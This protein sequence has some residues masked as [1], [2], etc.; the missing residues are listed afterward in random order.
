MTTEEKYY[1]K[2]FNITK[3]TLSVDEKRCI[4]IMADYA[5][6]YL[7]SKVE[8]LDISNVMSMLSNTKRFDISADIDDYNEDTNAVTVEEESK[9]GEWIRAND[10]DNII[11]CS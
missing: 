9:D 10:I 4:S 11:N 2:K 1:R 7:K 5:K 6:D 3:A 8:K